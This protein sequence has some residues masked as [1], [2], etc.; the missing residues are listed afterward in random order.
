MTRKARFV[1]G[2]HRLDVSEL[3]YS[4]VVQRDSIR[5]L[6]LVAALNDLDISCTDIQNAYL[7]APARERVFFVAGPEIGSQAGLFVQVTRALY[8]LKTSGASFRSL[9]SSNLRDLG[10]VA[11]QADPDVYLRPRRRHTFEYYEYVATYVDDILCVSHAPEEFMTRLNI[12]YTLKNLNNCRFFY[13][14]LNFGFHGWVRF[15][16]LTRFF[17]LIIIFSHDFNDIRVMG[18]KGWFLH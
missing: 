2:G 13:Y 12:L 15:Q 7:S 11:S 18:L 5:I 10:Y 4:S 8:G 14:G 1:A 17:F 16:W 9:L 6:L 3:T